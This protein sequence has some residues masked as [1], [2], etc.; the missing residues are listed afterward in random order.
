[1]TAYNPDLDSSNPGTIFID[2]DPRPDTNS[3]IKYADRVST[4]VIRPQLRLVERVCKTL[5]GDLELVREALIG[6]PT[7]S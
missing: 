7:E 1:M 2:K 3:Q 5:L 6:E 4:N